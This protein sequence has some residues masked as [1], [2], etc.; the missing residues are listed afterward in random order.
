MLTQTL[1]K[2]EGD[3][4][5]KRTVYATIPPKVE[6]ALTA[7]GQTL[8]DPLRSLHDWAELHV[9]ELRATLK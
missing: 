6:Y 7:L 9:E 1:R 2:L 5:V 4:L 8:V 3:G